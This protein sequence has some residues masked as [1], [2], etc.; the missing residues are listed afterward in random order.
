MCV[1]W[2]SLVVESR[3]TCMS[4]P[5]PSPLSMSTVGLSRHSTP[6]CQIGAAWEPLALPMGS[7]VPCTQFIVR[8][9]HQVML[10]PEICQ[11][12]RLY[13]ARGS[14]VHRRMGARLRGDPRLC[15]PGPTAVALSRQGQADISA[16]LPG[17]ES[18]QAGTAQRRSDKGHN[19]W[20]DG[21]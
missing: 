2:F 15:L 13:G 18:D 7:P 12:L 9:Q 5:A 21:G 3:L 19:S 1:L 11:S 20:H 17:A 6:D 10:G 14:Y 16:G 4:P 8:F